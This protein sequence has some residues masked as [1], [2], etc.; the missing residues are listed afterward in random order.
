M[1]LIKDGGILNL[2]NHRKCEFIKK[3]NI[4]PTILIISNDLSS[5]LEEFMIKENYDHNKKINDVL[6]FK[7]IKPNIVEFY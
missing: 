3:F 7:T 6:I 5:L 2:I 1:L 4:D